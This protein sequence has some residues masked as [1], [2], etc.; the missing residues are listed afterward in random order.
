MSNSSRISL[1]SLA[2][3]AAWNDNL[4]LTIV[5]YSSNAVIASNTYTLQVFTVSH[6]TF[7][8]YVGLDKI[9]FTTSGGTRNPSVTGNGTQFGM[10][11]ICLKFT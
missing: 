9:I 6:L 3:A 1:Y 8:G 7:T 10:D 5:G 4:Q 11:D 2:V